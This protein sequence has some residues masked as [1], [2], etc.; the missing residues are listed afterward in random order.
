MYYMNTDRDNFHDWARDKPDT[1]SFSGLHRTDLADLA[2]QPGVRW[3]RLAVLFLIG[4]ALVAAL[5]Y[6]TG[7]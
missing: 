2:G 4:V 5:K 3:G 7:R 1:T 6:L